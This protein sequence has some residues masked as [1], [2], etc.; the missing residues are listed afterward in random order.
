MV[1]FPVVTDRG[2]ETL[3]MY[4]A[5]TTSHAPF[6]RAYCDPLEGASLMTAREPRPR[7]VRAVPASARSERLFALTA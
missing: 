2:D 4:E 3:E 6:L 1:R 7:F 5:E